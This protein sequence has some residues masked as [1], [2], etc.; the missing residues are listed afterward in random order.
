MRVQPSIDDSMRQTRLR[1]AQRSA[2]GR[3]RLSPL[4]RRWLS[5]GAGLALPGLAALSCG[6]EAEAPEPVEANPSWLKRCEV[7]AECGLG[8]TCACGRCTQPCE[9]DADCAGLSGSAACVAPASGCAEARLCMPAPAGVGAASAG[10]SSCT[11]P[12]SDY[13]VEDARWCFGRELPECPPGSEPFVDACG[14]G[15][16]EAPDYPRR[17]RDVCELAAGEC[18]APPFEAFPDHD[19][20]RER[21]RREAEGRFVGL[22]AGECSNNGRRFLY[23]ANGTT[24]EARVFNAEGLF[25]GL[26]TTTDDVDRTC[27]GAGY[28]PEPARCE[29]AT[30]TEVLS[31]GFGF[32]VGARVSLPWGEGPPAPLF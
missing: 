6:A 7:D 26:G 14:C 16:S 28:W 22:A 2:A 3:A 4:A 19:T 23:T 20:T 10:A 30:I 18:E 24:S 15:C 9:A 27:W 8:A 13:S 17:C 29:E 5:M 11:H 32:E 25:L 21:W 12:A 31:E 1:L